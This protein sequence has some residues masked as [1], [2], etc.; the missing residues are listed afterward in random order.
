[1]R[2]T[3]QATIS[4]GTATALLILASLLVA[5]FLSLSIWFVPKV[6]GLFILAMGV[7]SRYLPAHLPI[8]RLGPANQVTLARLA[9]TALLGGCLGESSQSV[10]WFAVGTATL[11]LALD[12][13]DGWLARRGGWTSAFGAR[14]DM[15]TDALLILLIAALAWQLE[16]A[17]VWVLLSGLMR[18]LFVASAMIWPWL[19]AALPK[20]RRRQTVCVI[21]VLS[22]LLTLSPVVGDPW[23]SN[24]AV[25]GLLLLCYSFAA[26]VVWLRYHCRYHA[27]K[28]STTKLEDTRAL[29]PIVALLLAILFYL[30]VVSTTSV[31]LAE[32][33][34]YK[35][36]PDHLSIGFLK[37]HSGYQKTLG[38]LR[39]VSGSYR[40]DDS[41]GA[42]LDIEVAIETESVL[43]NPCKRDKIELIIGFGAIRQ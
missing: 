42:L 26:D 35:I 15:E 6:T 3:E 40:F 32:P 34:R 39:K 10:A 22:L 16:K 1:M 18:Y 30:C 33:A 2:L 29:R 17:G 36:D 13:L 28:R 43:N 11:V 31:A 19:G 41:S 23:S 37:D 7:I 14:F 21:Q 8:E 38:M 20:R 25:V 24:I 27:K 4:A 9:L 5:Q 12:G